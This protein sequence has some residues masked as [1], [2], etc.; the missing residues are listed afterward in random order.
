MCPTDLVVNIQD[1]YSKE[2]LNIQSTAVII[3]KIKN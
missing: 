3:Y 2:G 1:Q